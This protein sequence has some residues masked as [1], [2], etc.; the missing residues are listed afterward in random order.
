MD[1]LPLTS[2]DVLAEKIARIREEFPEVFTEGKID[3]ERLK[4]ALGEFVDNGR[5][6]Y[7]LF[8]AGKSE[9]IRNIQTPSVGTLLPVPEESVNFETSENLIIEGDN[10]EVLK[11]LQKSY[12]GK[13]KMIYIDPPYNTGGEFIYPDNFRE[14]LEDYLRYSGQ[15]DEDGVKLSTNTETSG[16]FHSKWLSMMYPRLFLARNLLQDDGVIFVSIDEHELVN[17]KSLLAEIFGEENWIADFVWQGSSKNDEQFVAM[18]HEYV[19]VF[20]KNRDALAASGGRWQE[21]KDGLEDIY[22][23]YEKIRSMYPGDF[24]RQTAELKSWY[25]GLPKDHPARE[26]SHY[27]VVDE[28][29]IYFPDNIS[30]PKFGQYRYEVLH[31]VTGRPCKEPAPGWR[32]PPEV[33]AEK[34]TQNLVHFGA[35]ETTI[36]C[37][38]S[39]LKDH[40]TQSPRSVFYKDGRAASGVVSRLFGEKKIFDNPKDHE[41]LARLISLATNEN[42]I[43]LDFFAGSGSTAHAV[44]ELNKISGNRKFILVQLPEP[45]DEKS[46]AYKAGYRTIAEITKER[47]RRVIADLGSEQRLVFD[48]PSKQDWGFKV[49][50]LSSSNF[51]VWDAAASAQNEAGLAEQLRFFADNIKPGR[52]QTDILYEVTLKSGLPLTAPIDSIYIDGCMWFSIGDGTLLICLQESIDEKC[53]AQVVSQSPHAVVCT[54]VAFH[55]NDNMKTNVKLLMESH[56]IEFH[57][58]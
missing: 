48:A 17:L 3:F 2:K 19:L 16:R 45:T 21:R 58:V 4:M 55:G 6:R 5:E 29:G 15:I 41:I 1:K 38:K 24:E 23:A 49:F 37:R 30:G 14:G 42:D 33:M 11:L 25:A 28:R 34:I 50:K 18:S 27:S 10:L 43:I 39:Y 20:A 8:W 26:H 46:N 40:E 12:H 53:W 54:D 47:V 7:G 51:K 56:G 32:Y 13:I 9:A 35:D 52:S 36:P 31:P 57:T 22:K 44:L